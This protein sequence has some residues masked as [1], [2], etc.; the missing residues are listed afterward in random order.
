MV[1][2]LAPASTHAPIHFVPH[3][4]PGEPLPQLPGYAAVQGLPGL[5]KKRDTNLVGEHSKRT[6]APRRV[7]RAAERD[8]QL[9][10]RAVPDGS[11]PLTSAAHDEWL[12]L[13]WHHKSLVHKRADFQH[14]VIAVA[15]LY[16]R[17]YDFNSHTATPGN[18]YLCETA[19][20]GQ[21]TLGR[22]KRWLK[23]HGFLGQVAG[24]RSAIYTPKNCLGFSNFRK[25]GAQEERMADR[26]V[27]VLCRPATE[28]ELARFG[29]EEAQRMDFKCKMDPLL[30]MFGLAVD[31]NGNPIHSKGKSSPKGIKAWASPTLKS[32]FEAA[33]EW[34]AKL[35]AA[36]T[37]LQW[38]A[39]KTTSAQDKATQEFNELQAARTVQWHSP[40][41]RKLGSRHLS[42][43][44]TPFFRADYTAADILHALDTTPEGTAH[45]HDGFD[46][47]KD[48]AALLQNRLNYWRLNGQPVYSHRRRA[49]IRSE[50]L[51]AQAEASHLR[52]E[53]TT[54][55]PAPPADSWR[56]RFAA[57][58]QQGLK[59]SAARC[60]GR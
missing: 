6:E 32:Y 13:I 40:P 60:T 45:R 7:N 14:N 11:M 9:V 37:D 51:R 48:I 25:D 28:E 56:T 21:G 18:K 35:Q 31:I 17:A 50:Q 46:G 33:T 3:V 10:L 59:E 23:R 55:R 39:T 30:G 19:G 29:Q 54:T 27:Y 43:I 57:D 38:P 5:W 20:I 52:Q 8:E 12:D 2:V 49:S 58:Y 47:A 22:V 34:V 42:R 4:V 16:R 44:L 24:G 36:R 53:P 15:D 26:A 1:P 41:L